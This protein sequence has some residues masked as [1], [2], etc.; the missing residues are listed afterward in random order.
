MIDTLKLK[1]PYLSEHAIDKISSVLSQHSSIKIGTGDIEY[2]I[3][4]G[5]LEGS[6]SNKI[7]IRLESETD[8][9]G[10]N[11]SFIITECSIQKA[12][13]GHNITGGETDLNKCVIWFVSHL[14]SYFDIV[15]PTYDNWLVMKIDVTECY[16]LPEKAITQY[17]TQLQITEYP[18]RKINRYA[19]ES[20]MCPGV[21]TTIKIYHKFH[22]FKK[23]DY[24]KLKD[25]ISSTELEALLELSKSILRCEVSIKLHK[26]KHDFGQTPLVKQITTEYLKQSWEHNI[27]KLINEGNNT[28][29]TKIKNTYDVDTRLQQI[30]EYKLANTLFGTFIK[31]ATFGENH[32]KQQM[33]KATFYRH[34][35]LLSDVGISWIGTDITINKSIIPDDFNLAYDNKYRDSQ[36]DK[37]ILNKIYKIA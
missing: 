3:T 8:F 4:S 11:Q 24:K 27:N 15:L 29:Y 14:S 10:I 13:I 30:Y 31:L 28:M 37:N 5:Y 1:S 6:Y 26:L 16:K 35:Q 23:H 33:S 22:E 12:M 20:I 9:Q 19:K 2:C 21:F 25:I 17:L 32:T 7:M 34:K 18:R 36:I